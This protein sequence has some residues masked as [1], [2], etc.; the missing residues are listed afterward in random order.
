MKPFS[1]SL[2]SL[3]SKRWK[4]NAGVMKKLFIPQECKPN[5][6]WINGNFGL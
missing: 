3:G 6:P 5:Y 1:S 2:N 4:E